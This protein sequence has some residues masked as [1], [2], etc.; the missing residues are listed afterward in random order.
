MLKQ[1]FFYIQSQKKA[2]WNNPQYN[3][4][5]SMKIC[6]ITSHKTEQNSAKW[7]SQVL[8]AIWINIEIRIPYST[9]FASHK[10][11]I[12][13]NVMP[14]WSSVLARSLFM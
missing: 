3:L 2:N 12:D 11:W 4:N 1:R 6:R 8:L 9:L 5:L 7:R 14:T 13:V 10:T